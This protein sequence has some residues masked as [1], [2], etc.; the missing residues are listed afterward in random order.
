[1]AANSGKSGKSGGGKPNP[2]AKGAKA[3]PM[4]MPATKPMKGNMPMKAARAKPTKRG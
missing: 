4:G 3:T 2:F 1:M